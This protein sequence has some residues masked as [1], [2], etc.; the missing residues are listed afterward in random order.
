MREK[1]EE[2]KEEERLRRRR[3]DWKAKNKEKR[4]S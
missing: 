1:V 3:G 4:E 2:E